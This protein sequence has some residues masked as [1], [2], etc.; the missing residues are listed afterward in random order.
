MYHYYLSGPMT[1]YPNFNFDAFDKAAARLQRA[2]Y[3]VYNPAEAFNRRQ[4][5]PWTQYMDHDYNMI[6][7]SGAVMVLEGWRSSLGSVLEVAFAVSRGMPVHELT[8]YGNQKL[9]SNKG[10]DT[11]LDVDTILKNYVTDS[12][13]KSETTFD[14]ILEEAQSLVHG[15]RGKH[16]GHPFDD[17]TKSA[18]IMTAVLYDKLKPGETIIAEDIPLIMQGVK[19]SREVNVPKRDNRV[20]GAGYWETLDMVREERNRRERQQAANERQTNFVESLSKI[21]KIDLSDPV[22][23]DYNEDGIPYWE[24]AGFIDEVTRQHD[25]EKAKL[26]QTPPAGFAGFINLELN[27]GE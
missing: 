5:L 6:L 18:M 12:E 7:Q 10:N 25:L 20:D 22:W 1:G 13:P 19:I 27:K 2:G 11:R 26:V 3:Q 15:D 24:Q 21:Q 23:D 17:F 9:F 14:S 8:A 4:D 16:Y